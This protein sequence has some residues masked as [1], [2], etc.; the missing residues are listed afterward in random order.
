MSTKRCVVCKKPWDIIELFEGIYDNE[1]VMVCRGCADEE[2]I[3]IL[4]KPSLEQ[5]KL[6]EKKYSVRERMERLSGVNKYRTDLSKEQQIVQTNINKLRMPEP[7]Q[8]HEDVVD[9]YYW[10]L[11]MARRRKKLTINQLSVKTS[12]PVKVLEAIER[13][14]LPKDF[15][16]IF[17]RLEDFFGIKL[18]KQHKKRINYIMPAIEQEKIL[19][20]VRKKMETREL[21][22]DSEYKELD[23][24][25]K[26]KKL[27]E[28][29]ENKFNLSK[30]KEL[31][32]ITIS[33]LVELKKQKEKKQRS[34]ERTEDFL[35]DD[36]ELV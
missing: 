22:E 24:R 13:G 7:K 8:K 5:L 32:D 29:R 1:M 12:I 26:E 31:N 10:E 17:V 4:R 21:D 35:G 14:K 11:N 30:R 16:Q 2:K 6:A 27:K 3:P 9:N 28:I 25:E 33:D 15:E 23:K 34:K 36:I 18:L 19:N 20:E